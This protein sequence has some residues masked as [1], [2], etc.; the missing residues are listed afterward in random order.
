MNFKV[1]ILNFAVT[2][3]ISFIVAAITTLL[4]NLIQS[5]A[6]T[7]DWTTSFRLAIILGVAFPLVEALR[8]KAK[9]KNVH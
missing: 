6:A 4:W 1:L 5:G 8:G 2:F 7:V 9:T 3:A